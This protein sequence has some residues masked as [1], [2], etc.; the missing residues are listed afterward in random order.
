MKKQVSGLK[1]V[2]RPR[3]NVVVSC[4]GADGEDNALAVAYATNC[5]YDPPMIM[6]GIVPSRYSYD[7]IKETGVYVVNLVPEELKEEYYYLGKYSGRD[8]DK[9]AELDLELEGGF[10]VDAPLLLDFPINIECKVVDSVKTGS[11]VMFIGEIKEVHVDQELVEDGNVKWS[12][13]DYLL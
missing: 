1:H 9:L 12:E 13:I 2:L 4:R 11:H 8:Q 10:E 5:S 3:P 7:L 6:V